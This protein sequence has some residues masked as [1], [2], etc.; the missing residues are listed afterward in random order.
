MFKRSST[1]LAL[2]TLLLCVAATAALAEEGSGSVRSGV[3]ASRSDVAITI[4]TGDGQEVLTLTPDTQLPRRTL[5]NG[6]LIWVQTAGPDSRQA[7][8]ILLI[9]EEISVVG[10]LDRER[11]VI[12][13]SWESQS[14][15][16]L[17]VRSKSGQE[18]FVIDPGT[19]HQP[20]PKKGER[21][22]VTYRV[23]N[24]KPPRY[25]ATGLVKLPADLEQ[26]PVKISYSPIPQ[27]EVKVA[28]AAPPVAAP[29][30]APT[31]A[32]EP[33]ALPEPQPEA[34]VASLPQTAR[35]TAARIAGLGLLL[36]LTGTAVTKFAR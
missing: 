4:W 18:L 35:Q 25:I 16:Q 21:V 7:Q 28:Q 29:E 24:T 13:D 23:E 14:P 17:V 31:T 1:L 20:L 12:G 6:N 15:S 19:F 30:A 34:I 32:S 33:M 2:L 11:A 10:Q 3:V 5:E 26:S 22:A 9:D 8:R 27:P 36:F